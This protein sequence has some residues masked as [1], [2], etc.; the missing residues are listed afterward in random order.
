[1]KEKIKY[2]ITNVVSSLVD[3]DS[4]IVMKFHELADSLGCTAVISPMGKK[5][6]DWKCEYN[7]KK[8]KRTLF[9]LRVNKKGWSVRCKLFNIEK[10]EEA[11]ANC[12]EGVKKTLISSRDC[13]MHGG[14]CK[15]PVK[16]SFDTD[17]HSKCRHYILFQDLQEE[18][19]ACVRRLIEL[20]SDYEE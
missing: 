17:M 20:E 15:G 5:E 2:D 10:Y 13:E 7:I 12:T 16:F 18:D 1:M 4:A 3:K 14:I 11:I 6:D 19:W 8:P 9:I